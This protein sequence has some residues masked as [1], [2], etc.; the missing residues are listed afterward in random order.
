[1]SSFIIQHQSIYISAKEIINTVNEKIHEYDSEY[2]KKGK[3]FGKFFTEL[4]S[5]TNMKLDIFNLN[6]DTWVEQTLCDYNDGYVEIPGYENKM[7]RFDIAEY[8]KNDGR[9]TISHLHGQI[10]FE[11]PQFNASDINRYAFQET[12]NTL[13]KYNDYSAAKSFRERSARSSDHTQSGE[14][15]HRTN[16]VTGLMKTDKLLWNPLIMYHYRLADSLISNKRLILVGYG[17]SDLYINNLLS[18][19]NAMH[20]NNRK[21]IMIDY[22]SDED[23]QPCVEHPFGPGPKAQFTNLMFRDDYWVTKHPFEPKKPVYYSTDEM[24][25]I[26]ING[27]S[28]VVKNHLSEVIEFIS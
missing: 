10:N 23:W 3:I 16:I 5:K 21:Q 15:L 28:D 24:A 2:S 20:F 6:Y 17:F 12:C 27:F 4:A 19:Y 7:K 14:N 22:I 25:R 18:Q 13:Y 11:Y 9:H 8:L 1:M 26:Y